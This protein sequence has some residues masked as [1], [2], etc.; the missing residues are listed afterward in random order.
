MSYPVINHRLSL[1]QWC[2]RFACMIW[3]SLALSGAVW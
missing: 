3:K 2:A 1:A